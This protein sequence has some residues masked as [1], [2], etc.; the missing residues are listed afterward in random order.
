MTK[1]IWINCIP[2]ALI[3]R[4]WFQSKLWPT[5]MRAGIGMV[6]TLSGLKQRGYSPKVVYD[7]GAG[8]GRWTR[9]ALEFW[10]ESTYVCFE[11]LAERKKDLD[12]LQASRSE[13][14]SVEACGVADADGELPIGVTDF[15]WD[16][17]FAYS[18]SSSR[19][20]PVRRLDSLIEAG[21]P[22]PSFIKIDVQGFEKR[23]LDGGQEAM[24]NADLILMECTFFQFCDEMRTLDVTIAYMSAHNFIPY[25]FVDY[26]R[27]PFDGAMGQCDI[28]FVRKGHQLVADN[29]WS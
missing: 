25:E 17:S 21:T 3:T 24:R 23:V 12:A 18:G 29:K 11:P 10:P 4:P 13:Q 22:L 6:A 28:L 14:I 7:I 2:D 26:L 9:Q 27:R 8:D 15:L 1:P 20:V 16:S 5:A 19:I